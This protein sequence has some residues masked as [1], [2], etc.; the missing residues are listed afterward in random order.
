MDA[1]QMREYRV[2]NP[3]YT[4]RNRKLNSARSAAARRLAVL[5]PVEYARLLEQEKRKRGL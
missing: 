1:E 3:D 2:D 4:Q 5:H